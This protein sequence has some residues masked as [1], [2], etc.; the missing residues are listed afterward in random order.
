MLIRQ[1]A[2]GA[3]VTEANER[4][5]AY[6]AYL[7]KITADDKGVSFFNVK[8]MFS[9]KAAFPL[10]LADLRYS[11]LLNSWLLLQL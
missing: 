4:L 9:R 8:A 6:L 11:P 7:K 3:A 10:R 1:Y 5:N 2:N